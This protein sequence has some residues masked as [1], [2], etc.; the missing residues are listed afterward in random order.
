MLSLGFQGD[1]VSACS[2][3]IPP[4]LP[5]LSSPTAICC[6]SG[7]REVTSGPYLWP[8]LLPVILPD[9]WYGSLFSVFDSL[10][11]ASLFCSCC[12][13]MESWLAL[14]SLAAP[15]VSVATPDGC[16]SLQNISCIYLQTLIILV[17]TSLYFL[18]FHGKISSWLFFLQSLSSPIKPID[19]CHLTCHEIWISLCPSSVWTSLMTLLPTRWNL[20]CWSWY[21]S[22]ALSVPWPIYYLT[23]LFCSP[24]SFWPHQGA[25]QPPLLQECP[26]PALLY[27]LSLA[28]RDE[29]QCHGF[30]ETLTTVSHSESSL[31]SSLRHVCWTELKLQ[32]TLLILWFGVYHSLSSIEIPLQCCLVMCVLPLAI[33]LVN[34]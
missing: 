33:Y 28:L 7:H 24:C 8:S 26:T 4:V 16:F 12:S 13:G 29:P 6:L 9:S 20:K 32:R 23:N 2:Y 1:L 17:H 22:L 31:L 15:G 11:P 3:L 5:A 25:F 19:F 10:A 27:M 18:N 30:S 34:K 14:A 21:Q